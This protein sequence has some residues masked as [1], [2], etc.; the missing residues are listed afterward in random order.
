M[1]C[2]LL[3]IVVIVTLLILGI[4]I[5]PK[6][7]KESYYPTWDAQYN[8]PIYH[9]NCNTNDD[10]G[11]NA[12]DSVPCNTN[13]QPPYYLSSYEHQDDF[14]ERDTFSKSIGDKLYPIPYTQLTTLYELQRQGVNIYN[15]HI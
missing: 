4:V 13:G 9:A 11:H 12:I 3:P 14:K 1:T 2:V 6:L 15:F 7:T 8:N 5:L 10:Q